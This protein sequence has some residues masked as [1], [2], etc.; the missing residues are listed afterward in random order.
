MLW[1]YLQA[2]FATFRTFSAG[3]FRPTAPFLTPSACYGLLLN[4]AGIEMRRDDGKSAM[5]LIGSD[6]PCAE[7]AIGALQMPDRHSVY[8]QLHNYPVGSSGKAHAP[9]CR[10]SKYNIAPAR[11]AFLSGL[12]ACIG[13][14]GNDAL[15]AAVVDGL[16]GRGPSRYGLPFLGDNS[17]LPDRIEPLPAARAARW[18]VPM[19]TDEPMS[20][21]A[22]PMRLTVRI[23][24]ADM[25]R[26]ESR[27]F[28]FASAVTEA[29]PASAWTAVGYD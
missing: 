15:A 21:E 4:L 3:S 11:R 14:R 20:M 13:L 22:E 26:T 29:V 24:R 7:L 9:A 23:D 5:T 12:S 16:E 25:S 10:G 8:Q 19:G 17:F 2:P 28:M 6:L 1:L 27:L 18:L